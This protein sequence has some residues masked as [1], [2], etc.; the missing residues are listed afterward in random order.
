MGVGRGKGMA[1]FSPYIAPRVMKILQINYE[2]IINYSYRD[3]NVGFLQR[4]STEG[5]V[6]ILC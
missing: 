4:L 3:D 6:D 2:S 1:R 5:L